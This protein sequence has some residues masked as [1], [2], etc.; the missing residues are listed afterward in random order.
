MLAS[1]ETCGPM[2]CYKVK[3]QKK[4]ADNYET[5]RKRSMRQEIECVYVLLL[6][7]RDAQNWWHKQVSR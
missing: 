2:K 4:A 5:S 7:K 3:L 6:S 1:T